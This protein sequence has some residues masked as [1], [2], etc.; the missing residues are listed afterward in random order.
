MN[1]AELSLSIA[2]RVGLTQETVDEVLAAFTDIVTDRLADGE[3]VQLFRF[4]TFDVHERG[5]RTMY[6]PTTK[7]VVSVPAR[8]C[9]VFKPGKD[10]KAL[11]EETK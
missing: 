6:N 4:G 9:V 1:K 5:Q 11:T 2:N 7:A 3:K 8:K 10:L